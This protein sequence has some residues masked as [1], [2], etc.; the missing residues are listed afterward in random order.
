MSGVQIDPITVGLFIVLAILLVFAI[1]VSM[2]MR[3][4][5]SLV[6]RLR[7]WRDHRRKIEPARAM[8]SRASPQRSPRNRKDRDFFNLT[9][10]RK[11]RSPDEKEAV[12]SRTYSEVNRLLN[13]E[14]TDPSVLR[15]LFKVLDEEHLK[16]Q[17]HYVGANDKSAELHLEQN[18]L[19]LK[20]RQAERTDPTDALLILLQSLGKYLERQ[21]IRSYSPDEHRLMFDRYRGTISSLYNDP[22]T[23]DF[24]RC[25]VSFSSF[26][27]LHSRH[28][29]RSD[30]D[31]QDLTVDRIIDSI[32]RFFMDRHFMPV[33]S[34]SMVIEL[35]GEQIQSMINEVDYLKRMESSAGSSDPYILYICN[36]T[37][38]KLRMALARDISSLEPSTGR[39]QEMRWMQ[40]R[41]TTLSISEDVQKASENAS[42]VSEKYSQDLGEGVHSMRAETEILR[43][44]ADHYR[45][46]YGDRDSS[47]GMELHGKGEERFDAAGTER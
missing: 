32:I 29:N 25:M 44:L 18:F 46:T 4:R 14:M 40:L 36:R 15:G 35:K 19:W 7:D 23:I 38:C 3:F 2:G 1:S 11:G 12:F 17:S 31:E 47:G 10:N 21:A 13:D 28:L 20:Y 16:L 9:G 34:A 30:A 24:N 39:F 33:A 43:C 45:S 5:F 27:F 37:T 22:R 41:R 26:C 8:N 6:E 42:S